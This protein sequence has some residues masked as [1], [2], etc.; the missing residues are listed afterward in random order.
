MSGLLIRV[1]G[2]LRS[3][4]NVNRGNMRL[5]RVRPML[6]DARVLSRLEG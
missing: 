2:G 1:E 3:R 6:L 5:S 4:C